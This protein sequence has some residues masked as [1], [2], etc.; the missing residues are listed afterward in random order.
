MDG[1]HAGRN[2]GLDD[3][4]I[5][6]LPVRG[7]EMD[8]R[9]VERQMFYLDH[10]PSEPPKRI[11]GREVPPD[12]PRNGAVRFE[13]VTMKYRQDLPPVLRYNHFSSNLCACNV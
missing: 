4:R 2:R 8:V 12:W 13:H 9:S 3:V 1:P 7:G 5:L 11:P 6:T 10:L